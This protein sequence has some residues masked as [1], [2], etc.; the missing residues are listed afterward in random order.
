MG[1]MLLFQLD[2]IISASS[3]WGVNNKRGLEQVWKEN[4]WITT[5]GMFT[6]APFSCLLKTCA[7]DRILYSVDYPF[8]GND[9]GLK[10]IEHIEASGIMDKKELE[11]F[12]YKNAEKLLKVKISQQV[13][14]L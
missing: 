8:S 3:S 9:R 4:F 5:S 14:D 13:R 7:K 10:F 6:L 2:R 11:M 1:E 12:C